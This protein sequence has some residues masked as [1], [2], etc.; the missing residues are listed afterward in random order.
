MLFIALTTFLLGAY[1]EEQSSSFMAQMQSANSL[2]QDTLS[3]SS[4]HGRSLEYK[5]SLAD[6]LV[7]G[8]T[9]CE[10]EQQGG[11]REDPVCACGEYACSIL[12]YCSVKGS[13]KPKCKSYFASWK[14]AVI[15]VAAVAF[16]IGIIIGCCCCCKK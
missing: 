2:I 9:P 16:L 7:K 4:L 8:L 13:E 12:Q 3:H 6:I 11:T 14:I 10:N 15:V 5:L 1:A